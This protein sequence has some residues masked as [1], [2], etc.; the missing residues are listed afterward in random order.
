MKCKPAAPTV[1]C[2]WSPPL[3]GAWIEIKT[4]AGGRPWRIVAPLAGG[5][6]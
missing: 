4:S 6:D 3:R 2:E 1:Y 5:V